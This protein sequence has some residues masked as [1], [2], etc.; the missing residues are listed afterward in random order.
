M[1]PLST[2]TF[3]CFHAGCPQAHSGFASETTIFVTFA[4]NMDKPSNTIFYLHHPLI[5]SSQE[6]QRRNSYEN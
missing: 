1:A 3:K 6:L 2:S 4:S 5:Q